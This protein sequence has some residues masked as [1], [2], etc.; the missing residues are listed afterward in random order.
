MKTM[1]GVLGWVVAIAAVVAAA[2]LFAKNRDLEAELGT[3]RDEVAQLRATSDQQ[4]AAHN[5]AL[6]EA[7]RLRQEVAKAESVSPSPSTTDEAAATA[8]PVDETA[9]AEPATESQP[10]QGN[11]IQRAQRAQM[12]VLVGMQYKG[13][14]DNLALPEDTMTS[15]NDLL[16]DSTIDAQQAMVEAMMSGTSKAK[17]AKAKQDA[18][19]AQLREQL[20]TVLNQEEMAQWDAYQ[21]VADVALYEALLDGQLTMLAPGLS[22]ETRA[23]ARTILA[24]DLATE[25]DT[26]FES[27]TI[28]TMDSFNQAQLAGLNNGM[29]RMPETINE[30]QYGHL[31]GF[32]DT[33]AATFQQMKQ[34]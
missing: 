31:T 15:V 27:D 3:Y 25:L 29:A 33:I 8:A 28:Y 17:D 1:L 9:A 14:L 7:E 32:I 4:G 34:K 22:E 13:F 2:T 23:A 12:G 21:E 16:I 18:I 5:E 19:E 24:E 11:S 26:F 6:A 10:N 20:G 30:E